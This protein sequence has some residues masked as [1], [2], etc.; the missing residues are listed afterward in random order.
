[1]EKKIGECSTCGGNLTI[2]HQCGPLYNAKKQDD[3]IEELKPCPLCKGVAV[4]LQEDSN[5]LHYLPRQVICNDCGVTI[6]GDNCVEIWNTRA[7]DPLM[8]EMAEA[9]EELDDMFDPTS[10]VGEI[11][12]NALQKYRERE[13][14]NRMHINE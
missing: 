6:E 9:L 14:A 13:D 8:E 12:N 4:L 1:M 7:T 11:I 2:D 5:R 3:E 10:R